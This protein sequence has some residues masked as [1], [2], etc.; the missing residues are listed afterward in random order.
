MAKKAVSSEAVAS[1]RLRA[2]VERIERLEEEKSALAADI[3]EIYSEAK[4]SGFDTKVL[5]QVIARRRK[6]KAEI[7][8]MEAL[9][10]M[11]ESALGE[12]VETP[13]GRAT[14]ERVREGAHA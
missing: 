6:D 1:D 5:R 2:F 4:S 12:Y 14:I 7:E 10:E 9:L 11:Y 8:E 3:R 13:L